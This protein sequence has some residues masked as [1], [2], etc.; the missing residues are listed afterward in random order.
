[1]RV[2]RSAR[3]TWG[4]LRGLNS[5]KRI[6]SPSPE[7]LGQAHHR[8]PHPESNRAPVLRRDRANPS[9]RTKVRSWYVQVTRYTFTSDPGDHESTSEGDAGIEPAYRIAHPALL[10]SRQVPRPVRLSPIGSKG[11]N[12]TPIKWLTA[13]R[14]TVVLPRIMLQ[15]LTCVKRTLP[16]DGAG[17]E[18][19]I[20]QH[21]YPE[22][23]SNPH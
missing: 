3:E 18:P 17:I 11:R 5:C 8:C 12:R 21:R 1:M 7:P 9:V 2:C 22:R 16:E 14:T 6:H 15:G 23:D 19:H 20:S 13:T 4:G 10:F